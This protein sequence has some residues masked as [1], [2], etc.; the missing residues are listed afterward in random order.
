MRLNGIIKESH[1][2]NRDLA[3]FN[4]RV[5]MAL[6]EPLLNVSVLG[7]KI[8]SLHGRIKSRVNCVNKPNPRGFAAVEVVQS[9][10]NDREAAQ[11]PLLSGTLFSVSMTIVLP[12]MKLL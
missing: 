6:T 3:Y 12:L 8:D 11:L 9:R 5:A 4:Y 10:I 7:I 2:T 1:Y